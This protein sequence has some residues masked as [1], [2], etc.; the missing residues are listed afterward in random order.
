M[1]YYMKQIARN[2]YCKIFIKKKD[3]VFNH[4]LHECISVPYVQA[5]A[6]K[7]QAIST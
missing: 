5:E 3:C 4:E 1:V 6:P 2:S 7:I